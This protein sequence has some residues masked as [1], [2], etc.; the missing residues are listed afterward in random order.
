[1]AVK[2]FTAGEKLTAADTNTYLANGGLVYIT[3][4]SWAT[5]A[6]ITI[7][8]CFTSTYNHYR[9]IGANVA[10]SSSST[11]TIQLTSGGT[12]A[13][14]NYGRQRLYAQTTTVG[15]TGSTGEASSVYGFLNGTSTSHFITDIFN[16]NVAT[17]TYF[18]T[19]ENYRDTDRPFIEKNHG[20]HTTAT[21]Y[22]GF[23][24]TSTNNLT[25]GTWFVYG[26]RMS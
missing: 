14:T 5:G 10:A 17:S 21:A 15:A 6:T 25:S 11:V 18:I 4:A 16:P 12:A 20:L 8:N 2:T 26:Y 3:Q 9:I 13:T 19:E 24:I 1:M 22:D 23:K 7:S